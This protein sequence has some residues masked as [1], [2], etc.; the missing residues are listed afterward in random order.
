[1]GHQIM[2]GRRP[3]EKVE[4]LEARLTRDQK[5]TIERA[6]ALSGTSVTNFV[7]ASAQAAAMETI[8]NSQ[9]L[10]L[11]G[12]AS[13]VFVNALLNPPAPNA[14]AKAAWRRYKEHKVR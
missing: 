7:V 10:T 6:A 1:M 2:A 8:K 9:I 12:K 4:R 14:A 11:R 5:Q 3:A 13:K